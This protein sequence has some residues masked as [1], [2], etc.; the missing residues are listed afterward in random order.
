LGLGLDWEEVDWWQGKCVLYD[1]HP[2]Y[3]FS[4]AW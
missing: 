1:T 2:L 4:M 3:S